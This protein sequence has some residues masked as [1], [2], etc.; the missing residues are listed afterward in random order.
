[1]FCI[2]SFII[3]AIIGI[4]SAS[5]RQLAKK[6]W[7]CTIKKVTFRPCDTSFK[8]ETKSKILSHVANKTP[9]LVKTADISIEIA[10]FIFVFLTIWSLLSVA[11]SG[12]N[13]F[14]WGTC[15]PSQASSCSVTSE[16]CSIDKIDK[17]FWQSLTEGKPWE[18]F[19]NGFIQLGDTFANIPNRLKYWNAEDYLPQ[20][21]TYYNQYDKSKPVAIE[22][23]D[24]GCIVCAKLFMN[25]KQA[26]FADRYNLTY[27]LYPIKDVYKEGE[28][29]FVNSYTVTEYL[30]A[31][32]INPLD[33]ID[34]PADWQILERIFYAKD[35]IGESYQ[36]IINT[37]LSKTETV[38]LIEGWL[39][40]IGYTDEMILTI[41]KTANSKE[42]ADII[43]N[44]IEIV[45]KKIN[46]L[47]IPTILFDGK[48]HDGSVPIR[49][50][51]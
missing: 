4:F 14:V 10:S 38:K 5:Q 36:N 21:A 32:K 24:P 18:W 30:E 9:K 22:I 25:I 39:K 27:I 12:L 34:T 50:L 42:I 41:R 17:S 16:T 3:L 15:T 33:N 44:N 7:Q 13:I 48:R 8:E 45:E 43:D 37:K 35:N 47:K 49:K 6:A 19:V 51:E 1:M 46:T 29:K 26:N 28:Y 40:E 31:I 11:Y 23:T 2:A 20:N